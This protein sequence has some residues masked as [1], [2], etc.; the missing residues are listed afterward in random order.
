MIEVIFTICAVA[1]AVA[2]SHWTWHKTFGAII[3]RDEQ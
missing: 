1:G 2:I 3:H